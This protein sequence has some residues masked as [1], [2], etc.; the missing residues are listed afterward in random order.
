MT[1]RLTSVRQPLAELGRMGV[2]LLIRLIEGQRVDALR[3]ELATQLVDPRIDGA[4]PELSSC[5]SLPS[6]RSSWPGWPPAP[7]LVSGAARGAPT[8][9]PISS[10]TG[11]VAPPNRRHRARQRVG[12]RGEPDRSVVDVERGARLEHALLGHRAQAAADGHGRRRP[13]GDRVLRRQG[14]C[15][16]PPRAPPIRPGSST[17]AR[18]ASCARG[19]RP[20]RRAGRRAARWWSTRAAEA[21]VFRGVALIGDT[22]YATDFHNG[23]VD[24]YDA[25]WRRIRRA[26]AF[27][28]PAIPSW[29]APFG[30][31]A[32]AASSS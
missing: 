24:V 22:V 31:Q 29:Y 10:P 20:C 23:R 17:P 7:R 4:A 5:G 25:N 8:P 21:A 11:T 19:H 9:S 26:G 13:D 14:A 32:I 6:R 1:P 2:S 18:T 3:V 12:D 28:D 27:E 30:V 15:A 16:S